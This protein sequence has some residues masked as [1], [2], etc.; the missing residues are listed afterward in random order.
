MTQKHHGIQSREVSRI[1]PSDGT[2][3]N[4]NYLFY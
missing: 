2:R 4:Y 1:T 3:K